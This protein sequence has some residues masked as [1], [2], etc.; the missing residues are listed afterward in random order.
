VNWIG[1]EVAIL[2]DHGSPGGRMTSMGMVLSAL[3]SSASNV[4]SIY[5]VA[6]WRASEYQAIAI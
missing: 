3:S 4:S 5:N 1:S 2:Y 6:R